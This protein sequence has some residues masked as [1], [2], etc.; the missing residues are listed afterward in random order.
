MVPGEETLTTDASYRLLGLRQ[1]VLDRIPADTKAE[2]R[3]Y[4]QDMVL[5]FLGKR[6]LRP[7][8]AWD[9][10]LERAAIVLALEAAMVSRGFRPNGEDAAIIAKMIADVYAWLA[11]VATGEREP[12]FV[13]SSARLHEMGPLSGSVRLSDDMMRGGYGGGC[14][15]RDEIRPRRFG[16]R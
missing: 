15:P 11:L 8:T 13:D 9:K 4:G 5:S 16:C 14:C 3:L 6:A 1:E 10:A 2:L 7:V 12:Y